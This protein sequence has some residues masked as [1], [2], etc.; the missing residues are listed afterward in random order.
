MEHGNGM[1][2]YWGGTLT[3]LQHSIILLFQGSSW[4][5]E[6]YNDDIVA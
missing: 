5:L 2:E 6:S 1:L 4:F 3:L